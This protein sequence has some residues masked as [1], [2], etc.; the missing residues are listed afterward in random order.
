MNELD[1]VISELI[2]ELLGE[3]PSAPSQAAQDAKKKGLTA[4]PF[5][6]WADSSGN[7]VARTVKG[8]LVPVKGKSSPKTKAQPQTRPGKTPVKLKNSPFKDPTGVSSKFQKLA[9]PKFRKRLRL[10]KGVYLNVSQ[11]AIGA[12]LSVPGLNL[13]SGKDGSYLHLGLPGTGLY[14][15]VNLASI[16]QSLK[17][18][19]KQSVKFRRRVKLGDGTYLNLSRSGVGVR[20]GAPGMTITGGPSGFMAHLGIPGSGVYRKFKILGNN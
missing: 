13:T 9:R 15:K 17:D 3:A 4:R 10:A 20:I 6:N 11:D 19:R 7:V 18:P 8:Q 5:G 1:E 16:R 2:E 12:S 14:R